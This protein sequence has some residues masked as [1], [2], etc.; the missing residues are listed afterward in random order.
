MKK[1]VLIVAI[2]AILTSCL[3]LFGLVTFTAESKIKEIGVRKVLGA[4]VAQ[5]VILISKDFLFLV[6]ISACLAFPVALYGLSRF[7]EGYAYRAP[8][9]WWVFAVAGLTT[10]LIAMITISFKCVQAALANP[11]K[12]LRSE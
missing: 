8:L 4:G 1:H 9:N 11:V 6:L 2:V 3:G 7:L 5:I 10:L 12:S